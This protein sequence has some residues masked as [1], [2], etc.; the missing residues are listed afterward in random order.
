MDEKN[1]NAAGR[2]AIGKIFLAFTAVIA[3]A[4]MLFASYMGGQKKVIEKY[5]DSFLSKNEQGIKSCLSA[6]FEAP[7]DLV[8]RCRDAYFKIEAGHLERGGNVHVKINISGEEIL[9]PSEAYCYFY[10]T[11]YNDDGKYFD[12][13]SEMR[14]R[15]VRS[16]TGWKFAEPSPE[17][18]QFDTD[19]RSFTIG[20]GEPG[21]ELVW[22]G[23]YS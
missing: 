15:L 3:V 21:P 16:G 22:R 4:A 19:E 5:Y 17:N 12:S 20:P 23:L 8:Q 9:S 13:P 1:S 2:K 14:V 11:F 18:Q 7:D 6:E 10:F